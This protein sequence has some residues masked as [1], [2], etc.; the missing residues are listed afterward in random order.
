LHT[1]TNISA[2]LQVYKQEQEMQHCMQQ[3]KTAGINQQLN[4]NYKL[5][6]V[7]PCTGA[8]RWLPVGS[9]RLWNTLLC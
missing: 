1:Q 2:A 9:V 7:Q 6:L 8:L 5:V 4:S 3:T